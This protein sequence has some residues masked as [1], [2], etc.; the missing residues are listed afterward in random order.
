MFIL[1]F[2]K[3]EDQEESKMLNIPR[4]SGLKISIAQSLK[5][6]QKAVKIHNKAEVVQV[7]IIFCTEH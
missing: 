5:H 4:R 1:S 6:N 2:L 7:Y 3:V